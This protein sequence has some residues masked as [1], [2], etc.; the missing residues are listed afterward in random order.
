MNI[1]YQLLTVA[2]SLGPLNE[3]VV[4]VG[5]MMRSL[6]ITDPAFDNARPTEDVDLIVD[7]LSTADYRTLETE[8]RARGFREHIEQGAPLCRWNV[9]GVRVDIMP[10]DPGILGFSNVWYATAH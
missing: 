1:P 6:L 4:F 5:G 8:L 9:S 10:V 7:V 2:R 3:R